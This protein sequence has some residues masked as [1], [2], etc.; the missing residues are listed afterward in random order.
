MGKPDL[1]F[2]ISATLM[3]EGRIFAGG[4]RQIL[5]TSDHFNWY[6]WFCP[7][8]EVVGLHV[9]GGL[10]AVIGNGQLA[11]T[12]LKHQGTV[13]QVV[14]L[15]DEP[16]CI[17]IVVGNVILVGTRSGRLFEIKIKRPTGIW[18]RLGLTKSS[19]LIES[20]TEIVTE[21]DPGGFEHIEWAGGN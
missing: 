18:E 1:D 10:L 21:I 11:V 4:P 8:D 6:G 19:P 17:H 5:V 15:A 2:E 9:D 7:L 16:T 20:A 12:M 14:D 13:W 3:S